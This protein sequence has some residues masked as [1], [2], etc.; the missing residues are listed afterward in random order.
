MCVC[1]CVREWVCEEAGQGRVGQSRPGKAHLSRASVGLRRLLAV[2]R[3]DHPRVHRNAAL[4]NLEVSTAGKGWAGKRVGGEVRRLGY[5]SSRGATCQGHVK[6]AAHA[7]VAPFFVGRRSGR[8]DVCMLCVYC[9]CVYHM[10]ACVCVCVCGR[11][12]EWRS[13]PF[14]ACGHLFV[15]ADAGEGADSALRK[16]EVDAQPLVPRLVADVYK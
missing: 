12:E 7:A 8:R 3:V 2:V 16:R 5:G 9:V 11:G 4:E 10:C 15:D 14:F 1:V 6:A 13:R